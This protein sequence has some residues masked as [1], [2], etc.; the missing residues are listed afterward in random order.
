MSVFLFAFFLRDSNALSIS[1]HIFVLQK[2]PT[3][4]PD[5]SFLAG[6][7]KRSDDSYINKGESRRIRCASWKG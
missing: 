7:K 2:M 3:R 6:R 5:A 1:E 4:Y